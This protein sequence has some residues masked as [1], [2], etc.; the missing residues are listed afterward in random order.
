MIWM[1][2]N[3]SLTVAAQLRAAFLSRD[4][5]GAGIACQGDSSWFDI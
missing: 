2:Y 1:S 3:R 4:R 5:Q